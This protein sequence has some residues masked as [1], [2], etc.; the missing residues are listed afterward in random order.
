MSL[1]KQFLVPPLTSLVIVSAVLA[2]DGQKPLKEREDPTQIGDRDINKRQINIFSLEKEVEFGKLLAAEVEK[3]A[4][5]VNDPVILGLVNRVAQNIAINSDSKMLIT[6]KVI[7][8]PE[9]NA[10]SLP[11][12]FL[13][14]NRG[15]I[16]A[17]EN[18]AELAAVIAHEVAH[19]AARHSIEQVSRRELI[20]W[21]TRSVNFFGGSAR[22]LNKAA[23][24]ITF[25]FSRG[26]E[27]EADRLA[28]QYLWKTGY[29][30]Q[31]L[32]SF[33]EKAKAQEK[34]T[35][36]PLER[37]FRT[38]PINEDR[39]QDTRKLLIRLPYKSEYNLNSSEFIAVKDR[40]GIKKEAVEQP[41]E[42]KNSGRRLPPLKRGKRLPTKVG[43]PP[44]VPAG[45]PL[46]KP[47]ATPP[48]KEAAPLDYSA[49][50]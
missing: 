12:G 20:G 42:P 32:I 26:A 28:V 47:P 21:V 22:P 48:G 23:G 27:E 39:I 25:R 29:D 40:P 9:I 13:F 16:E 8:S 49:P 35:R 6:A 17:T 24:V 31:A 3:N 1:I 36:F 18:E 38:H 4:I 37:L 44:G 43:L 11:G 10:F 14:V 30:P 33:L 19:I 7:D 15:L 45:A 46:P 50:E 34:K 2:A 5:M 41:P